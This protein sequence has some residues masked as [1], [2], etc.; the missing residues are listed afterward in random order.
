MIEGILDGTIDM[1]ATDHAPHSREEKSRGLQ[2]SAFGVVGLE[3]AFPAMYTHFVRTGILSM[4]ALVR[5]MAINPRK[6]F[7]IPLGTDFTVWDLSKAYA[8]D[9]NVFH[10]KGRATPF[11][12]MQM[13]G[14]SLLTVYG[15]KVV[16]KK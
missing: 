14:E 6:R 10:T 9:P 8:V 5:L 3:T 13:Y 7:G 15:G 4:E 11:D 2:G 12:G 16:Y 1:I